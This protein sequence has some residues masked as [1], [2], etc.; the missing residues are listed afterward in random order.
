MAKIDIA[1]IEGYREDMTP[2]EKLALLENYEIPE[3]KADYSGYVKKDVFDKKASEAA[4]YSK[5]LKALKEAAMTEE[6]KKAEAEKEA[7]RVRNE[8]QAKLCALEI[9]RIFT[10]A[11]IDEAEYSALELPLFTDVDKATAFANGIASMLSTRTGAAAQAARTELLA[12][13]TPPKE[14]GDGGGMAAQL[15][16]EWESAVK[17]GNMLEQ[18]RVIRV[19][20]ENKIDLI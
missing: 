9:S 1:S 5:E 7:E 11:G 3:T 8:Y 2:E 4:G 6:Q 19:A 13:G 20:Q 15:K 12:G 16:S 17:S 18:A 14:G 10:K